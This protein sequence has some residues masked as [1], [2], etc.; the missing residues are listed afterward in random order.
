MIT[1]RDATVADAAT[2][3]DFNYR[4][5]E[6]SEN[7]GLD[8]PRLEA[9][10]RAVLTSPDAR[11]RYFVA[12]DDGAI[13]GQLS[14]TYEWSDWRNGWLWWF[15][16][17]YVVPA[18]RRRG[19]FSALYDHVLELARA[20]ADVVGLR[21]YVLEN[22]ERAQQTYLSRG[23]YKTGYEVLELDFTKELK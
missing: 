19:V 14:V 16:S 15:Q 3:A 12:E 17:V 10:V 23:M 22:N 1:I 2:V 9:G 11:G 6:E 18:A 13:V 7:K 4:L 21:L 5:A 8:R 20:R